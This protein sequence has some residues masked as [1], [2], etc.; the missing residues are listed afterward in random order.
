MPKEWIFDSESTRVFSERRAEFLKRLLENLRRHIDLRSAL[1]AG[2]GIGYFSELLAALNFSVTAIDARQENID[3]AKRRF[4]G[5]D[6]VTRDVEDQQVQGLGSFDLV[7]CFG[8]L[9]HLENPFHAIRNLFAL[10][11]KLLVIETIV[12]SHDLPMAALVD[13]YVAEDQSI[14]SV[15]FIPSES[16]FIKMLFRSGFVHVY[17]TVQLPEHQQFRETDQESRRRTIIVAS[18]VP[19]TADL[20]APAAEIQQRE[21]SRKRNSGSA[22]VTNIRD[23]VRNPRNTVRNALPGWLYGSLRSLKQGMKNRP[24]TKMLSRNLLGDRDVENSWVASQMTGAGGEALDFGSGRSF[25][26]FVAA[27]R[28]YNV[29]ALNLEPVDWMYA[30]PG[31]RFVQGDILTTDFPDQHFDLIINCSTVEHVGL[32]G[33]Y[34]VNEVQ[35][36]GDLEAMQRLARFLKK[37]GT[38]LLTIPVGR[39]AVFAPMCR[40]YGE[41]RLKPLLAAYDV[42][43]EQYWIKNDS[44][45]WEICDKQAALDYQALASSSDPA[46]C[47]YALGCFVLSPR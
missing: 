19:V 40:V 43:R 24:T 28:G 35:S 7:L 31:L 17:K 3:E 26:G 14:H 34:G 6:F 38:M 33:R 32:A 5:I 23:A 37:N 22:L 10:T 1:D 41:I 42:R 36:D 8:L 18:R 13:E 27:Q 21:W 47:T 44:N 30:H 46:Q 39:D 12:T 11:A 15:A 2:C 29:T 25:L 9:Y 45:K 4:P 20:L 16:A